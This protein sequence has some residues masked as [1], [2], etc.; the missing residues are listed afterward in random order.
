VTVT[1]ERLFRLKLKRDLVQK[2]LPRAGLLGLS[3]LLA[4]CIMD[5]AGTGPPGPPVRERVIELHGATAIAPG[6]AHACAVTADRKAVCWGDNRYGQLGNGATAGSETPVRVSRLSNVTAL[7]AGERHTCAALATGRVECW[8]ANDLGQLANLTMRATSMPEL[9]PVGPA[10]QIA[11]GRGHTCAV[12]I[13]GAV[14]C[15]G[16]NR[17]GQTGAQRHSRARPSLP[18]IVPNVVQAVS[19]AAG[20]EHSCA[21]QEDG[22]VLCWGD[23]HFGQL[24]HGIRED[25]SFPP[26]PVPVD[27]KARAVTA[28]RL[29]TCALLRDGTVECWGRGIDGQLGDGLKRDSPRPVRVLRVDPAGGTAPLEKVAAVT[30]GSR[31]T[32]ALLEGGKVY[33]WGSNPLRPSGGVRGE[34]AVLAGFSGLTDVVAVSAGGG[35]TCAIRRGGVTICLGGMEPPGP[36]EEPKGRVEE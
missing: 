24:G 19:V 3:L 31:H 4:S 22:R 12:L 34:T 14:V 21:V 1:R 8:G 17:T 29:H 2:F 11:A 10:T 27:G 33:C 5:L 28:G 15:W 30:A 36:E 18:V 35:Q 23:N 32:C 7:A 13:N 16:D 26:R 9:T 20:A 6:G 25:H